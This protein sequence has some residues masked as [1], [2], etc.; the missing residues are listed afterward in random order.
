MV[1]VLGCRNEHGVAAGGSSAFLY[2]QNKNKKFS[3]VY[4]HA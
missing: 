3:S 1:G 4:L 2:T